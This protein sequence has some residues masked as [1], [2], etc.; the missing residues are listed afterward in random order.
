M[1]AEKV[2]RCLRTLKNTPEKMISENTSLP[3][4]KKAARNTTRV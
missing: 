1:E 4:S 3:R 2:V